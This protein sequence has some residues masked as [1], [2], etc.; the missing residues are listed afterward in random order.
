MKRLTPNQRIQPTSVSSLWPEREVNV[1]VSDRGLSSAF[2][3]G[4]SQFLAWQDVARIL[5]ETN[6]SGPWGADVW[7]VLEGADARCEFPQGATGEDAALAEIRR[8]FP[9]FEVKGM[10]ST[11][12]A[13]FICWEKGHAL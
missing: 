11:S 9:S 13:T 4:V 10:N 3:N 1:V 7:W 2:P 8:R 12:N 6:D 5:V